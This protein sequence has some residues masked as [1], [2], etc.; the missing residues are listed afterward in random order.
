M[1]VLVLG[2][3]AV[4]SLFYLKHFDALTTFLLQQQ[5][6]LRYLLA[7]LLVMPLGIC[8]G[9][10]FPLAL[11]QLATSKVEL[12][13]WAWGVNGFASVISPIL[14]TLIAMQFGFRALLATAVV[15]YLLAIMC[16]PKVALTTTD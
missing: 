10:P 8:M 9:V 11:R 15:L 6:V 4:L 2:M 3:L 16:F 5:T 14:A 1:L 13:P 7:I 12:I